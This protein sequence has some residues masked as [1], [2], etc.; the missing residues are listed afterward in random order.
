MATISEALA[1][2][3]Q[4]H[5]AGRLAAAEQVYRQILAAEPNEPD[6]WH[7]LGFLTHQMGRHE[8]AV[9]YIGRAIGLKG[10][11]AVFHRNMAVVYRALRRGPE[12]IAYCRRAIE[13]D[14]VDAEL[15]N[16]LG[17]ILQDVGR[18][19]EAVGSHCRAIELRPDFA[20]AH[21]NLGLALKR[22]GR[23]EEAIGSYRRALA[24]KPDYADA[25]SN[26][27]AALME[28]GKLEEALAAY[29]RALELDPALVAAADN[30]LVALQYRP[31]ISLPALALAHAEY[32][33]RYTGPL[34]T[35]WRPHRNLRDPRRRLRLGF[36]SPDFGRHPV[37]FFLVGCLEHLDPGQYE[38]ACYCDR[39]HEDDIAPRF[40]AAAALWREVAGLDD[41]QLADQI[42]ADQVDILFDLTGHSAR[43]RLLAFARKPVPLQVTWIGYEGTTGLSAMDY[44]LADRYVVPEGTEQYYREQVLRMPEGYLC[45]DPPPAA[46]PVG[47]LPARAPGELTF[48]SFNN[49][50]KINSAVVKVWAD[51][52]RRLPNARLV[53]KYQG[54]GEE[55]MQQRYRELFAGCGVGPKQLMLL[56]PSRYGE[57]LATYQHIDLALDPFPFSGSATTCEALWMGVPVVTCPGETFAGRHSLSHLSNVGLTETIAR[58]LDE[59]VEIAVALAGDL[60]RLSAMRARLRDQMAA[61]PLC[62]GKRFATN[63]ATVLRGVWQRW[64]EGNDNC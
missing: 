33:R 13:L 42:S 36:V 47:S 43:N 25:Q 2:A 17:A 52:L 51:I 31:G 58:D 41:Q 21:F 62:D 45:Y 26:L 53:L 63:L 7:L 56:P 29:R 23:L 39:V 15:H 22:L 5:Q 54:L 6:A 14:R 10:D 1:I 24:L 9:E 64:C 57:Y 3:I 37:G 49:L 48:G 35:A 44:L 50:G 40:R 27:G 28:E 16:N 4:H 11:A 32:E 60:P 18:F 46:P 12:A 8:A 38:T 20:E 34:R 30:R 19:E 61:S 55:H 59:Y